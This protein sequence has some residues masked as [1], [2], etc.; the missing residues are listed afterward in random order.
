MSGFLSFPP[1]QEITLGRFKVMRI[2]ESVFP[3]FCQK[4]VQI[5]CYYA[6]QGML[7]DQNPSPVA[8][9]ESAAR[10]N[11]PEVIVSTGGKWSLG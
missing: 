4:L 11:P 3:V 5:H 10:N 8:C 2:Q 9:S 7:H 6:H 1:K